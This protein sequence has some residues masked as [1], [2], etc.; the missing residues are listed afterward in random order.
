MQDFLPRYLIELGESRESPYQ[1]NYNT[2][3]YFSKYSFSCVTNTCTMDFS[4]SS[5]LT[6]TM[7]V[8]TKTS[9]YVLLIPT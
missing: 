3:I 9:R 2:G 7:S 5:G 6:R 4:S 8:N 1:K